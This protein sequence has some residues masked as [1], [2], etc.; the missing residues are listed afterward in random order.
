[1]NK[2]SV[3]PF[4][5]DKNKREREKAGEKISSKCQSECYKQYNYLSSI[6]NFDTQEVYG[7]ARPKNPLSVRPGVQ[8]SQ[9]PISSSVE[10]DFKK[11]PVLLNI[12]LMME[13][14]LFF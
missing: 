5:K 3:Y 4:Q 6:L 14:M 9:I 10:R 2:I 8:K 11:H 7:K 12:K 13:R 1:M